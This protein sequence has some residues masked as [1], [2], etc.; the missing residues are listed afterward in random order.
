M[1]DTSGEKKTKTVQQIILSI[2]IDMLVKLTTRTSVDSLLVA[3]K[4]EL[5]QLKTTTIYE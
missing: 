4:S 1:D 2:R 3:V 5:F